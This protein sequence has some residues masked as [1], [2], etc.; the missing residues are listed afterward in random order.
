MSYWTSISRWADQFGLAVTGGV[1][2][3]ST[4]IIML[5]IARIRLWNTRRS[6]EKANER[7]V[8]ART[9][10]S[11]INPLDVVFTNKRINLNEMTRP[12]TNNVNGKTFVQCQIV[13]PVNVLLVASTHLAGPK[14]IACE[15]VY[16]DNTVWPSNVIQL[17]DCDFRDCEFFNVTFLV[18][19]TDY[20]YFCNQLMMNW[21]TRNPRNYTFYRDGRMLQRDDA[22]QET[23][24]FR[25]SPP[26]THEKQPTDK[27]DEEP[28][29]PYAN[30]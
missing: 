6:V 12:L 23:L 21:I 11:S 19:D 28:G 26:E 22:T 3:F 1:G 18:R 20:E 10:T 14:G 2:I 17:I 5:A 7:L 30:Q 13:G 8:I 15:A 27:Q 24:P 29:R 9:N 25:E 4:L 16:I